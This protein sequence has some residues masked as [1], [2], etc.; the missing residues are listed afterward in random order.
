MASRPIWTGAISF[1]MVSI[2]V[3]LYSAVQ[4]KD[5]RFHQIHEKCGSRI[6]QL[7]FCPVCER[8]VENAE[9]QKGYEFTKGRYAIVTEEDF[10]NVPV[11]T[12]HTITVDRFVN[13]E[14]VSPLYYD[15]S[16]YLL[17][18]EA[19]RKPFALLMAA[20]KKKQMS[21]LAKMTLRNKEHLCLI[22]ISG[23]G[24]LLETLFFPDEIRERDDVKLGEVK[25]DDKEMQMALS[26]IDLLTD[27]FEPERYTD[28]YREALMARVEAKVQGQQIQEQ[29]EVQ[30]SQVIDLFEALK[31][32][33][34]TAKA[35]K[36][37]TG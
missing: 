7:K 30:E 9:L 33:L 6:K 34:E 1:G 14:E 31:A 28:E 32:S 35:K 16:Y 10:E 29:P 36:K 15:T 5:L 25:V 37:K 13:E 21:A 2:P 17:P 8:N 26:L 23:E 27:E 18:E 4:E 22:M 19:G 3:G 24:I 12:K 11:P 20:L